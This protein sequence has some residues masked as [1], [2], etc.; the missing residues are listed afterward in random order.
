MARSP[1]TS[2]RHG[3]QGPT[4]KTLEQLHGT[5]GWGKKSQGKCGLTSLLSHILISAEN[6]R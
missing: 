2:A 3:L 1:R 5:A 4:P 6:L